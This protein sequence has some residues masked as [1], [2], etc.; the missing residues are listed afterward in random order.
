VAEQVVLSASQKVARVNELLDDY[1]KSKGLPK[2]EANPEAT[3][4]LNLSLKELRS[5]SA[6]EAG[7]SNVILAQY[8]L[9]IQRAL[10]EEIAIVSFCE[11]ELRRVLSNEM[12][13]YKAPSI[14][15]RKAKAIE[16]NEYAR[17]LDKLRSQSKARVDRLSFIPNRIDAI[18]ISLSELQQTKRDKRE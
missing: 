11:T 12:N 5:I 17:N 9:A 15:E 7:E 1:E 6:E 2:F 8:A 16:G 3:K 18:R 14:E 10:N 13:Q 4:Y